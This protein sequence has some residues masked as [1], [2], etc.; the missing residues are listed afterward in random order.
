MV[1]QPPKDRG[2]KRT[3]T[4]KTKGGDGCGATQIRDGERNTI[5]N[6][7]VGE[8]GATI[9]TAQREVVKKGSTQAKSGT[10]RI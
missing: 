1:Q 5:N 9:P 7:E 3:T 8:G 4:K 10:K 2:E 6:G